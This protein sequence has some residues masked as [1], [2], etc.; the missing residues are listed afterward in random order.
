MFSVKILIA[1]DIIF[2]R[3]RIISNVT[4]PY[5]V[6]SRYYI[7]CIYYILN[8]FFNLSRPVSEK[9]SASRSVK[10]IKYN[11]VYIRFTMHLVYK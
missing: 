1:I 6:C 8:Y 3:F 10:N 5:T 11:T 7:K 9:T 2:R 4:L